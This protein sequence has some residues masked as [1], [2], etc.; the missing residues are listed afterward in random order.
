MGKKISAEY[1]RF[2]ELLRRLVAVPKKEI[3]EEL[4]E[5]KERR[6]NKDEAEPEM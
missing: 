4:E 3:E 5:Y 2:K 1:D 6:E